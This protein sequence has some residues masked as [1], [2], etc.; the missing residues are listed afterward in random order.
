M[1]VIEWYAPAEGS[2]GWL[3]HGTMEHPWPSWVETAEAVF[4]RGFLAGPLL[5]VLLDDPGAGPGPR[6][7]LALWLA[8]RPPV[9]GLRHLE[10]P[11]L[12]RLDAEAARIE[13]PLRAG[14]LCRAMLQRAEG[15]DDALAAIRAALPMPSFTGTDTLTP[16]G[17]PLRIIIDALI[18]V[19]PAGLAL[20]GGLYDPM[21][22]L[23]RV[24]L[25]QGDAV[26]TLDRGDW[27]LMPRPEPGA[28][29]DDATRHGASTSFVAF[30]E[31]PFGDAEPLCIELETR[32][33]RI[34]HL[35]LPRPVEA[36]GLAVIEQLLGLPRQPLLRM[37]AVLSRTIGPI[38]RGL[39]R[40]RL[41]ARPPPQRLDFGP[42][43]KAP[44]R[45]LIIPLHG[46]VD[47]MALQLALFSARPDPDCEILYVLDDPRL[48]DEAERM[49]HSCWERFGLPFSLLDLGLHLGY[50]PANNA[51]LAAARAPHLCL[52][53]ADV[54][55]RPGEGMA[56]LAT[57]CAA[58]G[59]PGTGAVGATLLF[60][61]G[62]LQHA[63]MEYRRM[64][65]LPPWP[66]PAHPGNGGKP[67]IG[68][69]V[70][71]EVS[72]VT[73]AC[74]CLRRDDLFALGGL[75]EDCIIADFEDAALC[76][77]LRARGLRI[78]LQAD[79]VLYHLERQTPGSNAPWRLGATLVNASHFAQR[80]NPDAQG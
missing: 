79:V 69:G 65:G 24:A 43:P 62:T 39:N 30:A 58:L 27:A 13:D 55:P 75:D 52:L 66:F 34:A 78:M 41:A 68:D 45:A 12:L 40:A 33:G 71:R 44:L 80:W 2:E 64:P 72:A 5:S 63:G 57:L 46:R 61:D 6:R 28:A 32:D 77:A 51:G 76:E 21:R 17:L 42:L 4:E 20:E 56:W 23:A 29:T 73:G 25:R 53:N 35:P 16:L 59:D 54:F 37:S 18:R 15:Q 38:A 11:A 7:F 31:G 49:A 48:S 9:G 74:L 22:L 26:H 70:A 19:P 36:A 3:L 1:G 60:E 14:A 10:A 47:F 8:P 50:A 67:T